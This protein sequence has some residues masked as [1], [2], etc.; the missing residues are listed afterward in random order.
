M[1]IKSLALIVTYFSCEPN[2]DGGQRGS[3]VKLSIDPIGTS[4]GRGFARTNIP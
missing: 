2:D 1:K 4:M 3:F